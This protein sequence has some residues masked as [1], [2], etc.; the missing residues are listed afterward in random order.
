MREKSKTFT[1]EE[2]GKDRHKSGLKLWIV[3]SSV[4]WEGT[5]KGRGGLEFLGKK[6]IK[7]ER[8]TIF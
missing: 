3:F 2:R 8:K 1:Q 7:K 6:E 4:N 5:L